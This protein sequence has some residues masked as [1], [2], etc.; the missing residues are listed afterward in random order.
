MNA[1]YFH[2]LSS[3]FPLY[4]I[5]LCGFILSISLLLK[6]EKLFNFAMILLVFFALVSF[7]TGAMG[8]ASMPKVKD[9]PDINHAALHL[10]AW[11]ALGA[12]MFAIVLAI[13]A[14]LRYRKKTSFDLI[15]NMMMI[16][17]GILCFAFLAISML[18]GSQIRT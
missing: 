14:I 3:W 10:H 2:I 13:L 1:S 12:I 15:T 7:I 18:F 5:I 8:G 4:L 16:L 6:S 9:Q 17:I 11:S